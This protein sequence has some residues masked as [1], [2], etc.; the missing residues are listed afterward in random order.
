MNNHNKTTEELQNEL[1]QKLNGQFKNE[2]VFI[3]YLISTKSNF[4]YRYLETSTDQDIQIKASKDNEFSATSYEPNM[5]NAFKVSHQVAKEGIKELAKTVDRTLIP[6]VQYSIQTHVNNF[7]NGSGKITILSKISWD[8]PNYNQE[9]KSISKK[10]V[11]NFT[12]VNQ[13]RKELAL[14]YEEACELFL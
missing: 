8:F 6:K 11:F 1:I 13:F 12:D 4:L 7:N 3:D 2:S 14:K 10:V 5:G 9:D